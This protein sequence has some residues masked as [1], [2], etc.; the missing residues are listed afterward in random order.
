MDCVRRERRRRGTAGAPRD[1]GQLAAVRGA[2][3][4]RRDPGA[5]RRR[6]RHPR[7]L[8]GLAVADRGRAGRGR[9]AP[10]RRGRRPGHR[11]H[12][13]PDPHPLDVRR[14]G[15][16]AEGRVGELRV[17][18]PLGR[19]LGRH[20]R[21]RPRHP[22]RRPGDG[23]QRRA[24]RA[25]GAQLGVLGGAGARPADR[26][27]ARR[28]RPVDHLGPHPP[29]RAGHRPGDGPADRDRAAAHADVRRHPDDRRPARARAGAHAARRRGG[30]AGRPATAAQPPADRDPRCRR[31]TC[32]RCSTATTW[33][34][35]P[36]SRPRSPTSGPRSAASSP[37][38]PTG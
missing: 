11:G 28:D 18:R 25:D 8:G 26:Q 3:H 34:R 12:R 27:A 21:A 36:R 33:S 9:A 19:H 5:A 7:A 17:R 13:R 23:V 30:L 24:L 16:A 2:Q 31:S 20:Q 1:P 37:R 29:D 38:G 14:P 32:T 22:R 10:H 35:R 4:P 6:G 15:D